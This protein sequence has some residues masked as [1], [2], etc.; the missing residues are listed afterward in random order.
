MLNRS[1]L[2]SSILPTANLLVLGSGSPCITTQEVEVATYSQSAAA[3]PESWA[4]Q[5]QVFKN[6]PPHSRQVAGRQAERQAGRA[7]ALCGKA[8][9]N[10]SPQWAGHSSAYPSESSA[11]AHPSMSRHTGRIQLVTALGSPQAPLSLPLPLS[12]HPQH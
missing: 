12:Q 5:R 8:P 10:Y 11:P 3:E 1:L 9:Q 2:S 6:T 7:E 4:G